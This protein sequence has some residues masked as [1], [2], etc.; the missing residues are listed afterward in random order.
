MLK[1]VVLKATKVDILQELVNG[2]VENGYYNCLGGMVI[3][4]YHYPYPVIYYQ[5]MELKH[6]HDQRFRKNTKGVRFRKKTYG[7]NTGP[8]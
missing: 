5:T 7:N 3:E 2:F 8:G 1:Y 6:D 4:P